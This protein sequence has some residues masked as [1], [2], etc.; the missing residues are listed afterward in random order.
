MSVGGL[1]WLRQNLSLDDIARETRISA[2]FLQAI[3]A[4]DFER[5]PGLVFTRNFVR[6]YAEAIHVDADPLIAGLP[7]P[8]LESAPMP[9][10]PWRSGESRWDPRWN[11]A[12][13]SIAWFALATGAAGWTYVH[14]NR[15]PQIHAEKAQT[16]QAAAPVAAK[17]ADNSAPVGSP[18]S[19]TE[20]E[21]AASE[22][23]GPDAQAPVTVVSPGEKKT[24][25]VHASQPN[26][27]LPVQ[28]VLTARET[29][30]VQV[31]ADGKP[32]FTG[33]MK[34]SDSRSVEAYALVK[35]LA[36]NAGGLEISLNGRQLD[37]IGP[38]GQV[39]A[40]RLTAEGL[41]PLAKIPPPAPDPL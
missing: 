7:K 2:R 13:A 38:S 32:A 37:P 1:E 11:S 9:N 12:I 18:S 39:R 3:E 8:N 5:L 28:V 4:E 25:L 6:Q 34:P 21:A 27:T 22:S 10:P 40:V 30:W 16:T 26:A 35:I 24:E 17:P 41:Q 15:P 31:T 14:F 33:T 29:S 23:A 36:G 19:D 20:K